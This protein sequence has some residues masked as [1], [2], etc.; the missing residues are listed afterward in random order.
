VKKV[1]AKLSNYCKKGCCYDVDYYVEGLR[2]PQCFYFDF[3]DAYGVYPSEEFVD[4]NGRLAI[5]RGYFDE[6]Q[7][8]TDLQNAT[9]VTLQQLKE[10]L[11]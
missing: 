4:V 7:L 6:D 8:I 3:I 9:A 5:Q 11:C 10:A 2:V 1:E